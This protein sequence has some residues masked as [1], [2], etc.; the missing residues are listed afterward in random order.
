MSQKRWNAILF[1]LKQSKSLSIHNLASELNVSPVTIRKDLQYLEKMGFILRSHGSASF[2]GTSYM[3]GLLSIN[4]RQ[5]SLPLVKQ[6]LSQKISPILKNYKT[7]F[8]DDSTTT[9]FLLPYIQ[10]IDNVTIITNSL[11]IVYSLSSNS[12]LEIIS[13]GGV[14]SILHQAFVGVDAINSVSLKEV[15][16]AFL[17]TSG[18]SKDHGSCENSQALSDIKKIVA[19]QAKE[20]ILMADHTKF[21][22]Q[23]CQ[24]CIEWNNI[25]SIVTDIQPPRDF[26]EILALH[27]VKLIIN[28]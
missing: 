12:K 18:F 5:K 27:K 1:L 23:G 15:D 22:T 7:I 4:R 9:S 6:Q 16:I 20:T 11:N 28:F 21:Y 14:L 8:I 26:S 24:R 3:S 13:T 19:K 25:S 17:G 10:E 2:A